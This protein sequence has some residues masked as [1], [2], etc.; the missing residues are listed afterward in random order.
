[1][2]ITT[3]PFTAILLVAIS[4]FLTTGCQSG[5]TGDPRSDNYWCARQNLHG[6]TY[7]RQTNELRSI[8]SSRQSEEAGMRQRLSAL[9]AKLAAAR[10]SNTSGPEVQQLQAEIS[11]LKSQIQGLKSGI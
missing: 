7:A 9:Q 6:G 1:M 3:H 2:R 11:S 4:G 8:A 5:C 10:A